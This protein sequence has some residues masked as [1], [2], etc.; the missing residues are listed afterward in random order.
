[1]QED[2]KIQSVHLE[3]IDLLAYYIPGILIL[4]CVLIWDTV[5]GLGFRKALGN[6]RFL[7]GETSTYEYGLLLTVL[8][9][10]IPY[11]IGHLFFPLSLLLSSLF[12]TIKLPRDIG[13]RKC[14]FL[15]KKKRYC[16]LEEYDFAKCLS[17]AFL[18][19]K[20]R[21]LELWL[22][23][24]RALE[25]FYR[26]LILPQALMGISLA[27]L[28]ISLW[29][30][31]RKSAIALVFMGFLAVA[32]IWGLA[33]RYKKFELRWRNIVCAASDTDEK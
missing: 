33:D 16:L 4:I 28:G 18:K 3:L 24:F 13:A 20:S 31:S 32:S 30:D 9:L 12:G 10:T 17:K 27:A 14:N 22:S 1:M 15:E 23:R 25:R 5:L 29:L 8:F 11:L 21:F 19:G 26:A 2:S 7:L 6:I